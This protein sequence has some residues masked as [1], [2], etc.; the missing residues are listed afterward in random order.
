MEE[1]GEGDGDD[2]E[3]FTVGRGREIFMEMIRLGELRDKIWFNLLLGDKIGFNLLLG[4][5]MGFNLL[6]GDKIRL[7]C[8]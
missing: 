3:S 4:D 2:G 6:L 7:I 8:C 1:R 5:K